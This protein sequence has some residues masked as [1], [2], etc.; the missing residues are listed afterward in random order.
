M[1]SELALTT[2][3][4]TRT[5]KQ[6]TLQPT[7]IVLATLLAATFLAPAQAAQGGGRPARPA[8]ATAERLDAVV[9]R[10][11]ARTGPDHALYRELTALLRET[12]GLMRDVPALLGGTG[13]DTSD[14]LILALEDIGSVEAQE[15]LASILSA[16]TQRRMDRLRAAMALGA[17]ESPGEAS[18][19]S[20]WAVSRQRSDPR[21]V[22]V[23]NTALLALGSAGGRLRRS[24]SPGYA[25]LR[26]ALV[27]R[28]RAAPDPA[29]RAMT[30]KAV[31]NLHDPALGDE[32]AFYLQSDSAPVR[33]SAAQSLGL[34][35]DESK[36]DLLVGLLPA[37]PR[38]A[39]RAAMADALRLFTADK[40]SLGAM[41]AVV[42][43]ERHHEARALLVSYL[44]EHLD[45]YEHS[46]DTLRGM[47]FEDPSNRVRLLASTALRFEPK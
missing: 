17:V 1:A 6:S 22:D 27:Q 19:A 37:E 38:G 2:P 36:R 12:P 23:S 35:G 9:L 18:L 46:L 16:A 13:L 39:V 3:T 11:E 33:A 43:D 21:S 26:D 34:L 41:L 32:V 28:L 20:L 47:A 24:S 45:E 7:S 42:R 8:A 5:M 4:E 44:V 31:G 29:E 10:L 25:A 14:T 15:A 40:R 30:L